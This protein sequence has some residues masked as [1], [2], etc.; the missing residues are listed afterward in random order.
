MPLPPVAALN[1]V[2][3]LSW[4][5][6]FFFFFVLAIPKYACTKQLLRKWP[7][8]ESKTLKEVLDGDIFLVIKLSIIQLCKHWSMSVHRKAV[9]MVLPGKQICCD[10]LLLEARS[11]EQFCLLTFLLSW[12][13]LAKVLFVI[14]EMCA[15]V[16]TNNFMDEAMGTNVLETGLNVST[17]FKQQLCYRAQT[18]CLLK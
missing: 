16:L 7:D 14:G 3:V 1:V 8:L 9:S 4:L 18:A 17:S 2:S 11:G 5:I 13:I 15:N 12:N 10:P 6:C